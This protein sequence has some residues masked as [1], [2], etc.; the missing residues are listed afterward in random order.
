LKFFILVPNVP[1]LPAKNLSHLTLIHGLSSL[2]HLS[3]DQRTS[4]IQL[5]RVC[6]DL[7]R[8]INWYLRLYSREQSSPNEVRSSFF[9]FLLQK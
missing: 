6:I 9:F 4:L 1:I 3:P 2:F 7:D 5:A 8:P